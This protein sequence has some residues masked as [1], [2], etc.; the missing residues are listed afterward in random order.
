M[1]HA[2]NGDRLA[3]PGHIVKLNDSELEEVAVMAGLQGS[4]KEKVR[5]LMDLF[6]LE[7]VAVTAGAEGSR[8]YTREGE[9]ET[10]PPSGVDIVDTVGAGDAYAAVLVTGYLR[11]WAPQITADRAS[12][13]AGMICGIEGAL[14]GSREPYDAFREGWG[15]GLGEG[16]GIYIQMFSIHG[17][18][19]HENMELGRDADTGGQIKYVVELGRELA[20]QP[21]IGRVDLFTRLI[22]DRGIS[23]DYSQPVTE[24]SDGFRII[25]IQ[26]GGRKYMRKELLWDHLDEYADRTMKFIKREGLLPDIVHG[27]YADAGIVAMKLSGIFD[28]PFV[29][30]GHS[31]GKTKKQKLLDEGVREEEIIKRFRIDRRIQAE[32]DVLRNADLVVT[33]TRQEMEEQYAVYR[34]REAP[35]YRV[36]PPGVEVDRFYPFYHDTVNGRQK[37][38]M[39]LYARASVIAELDRFF[40]NR[41]KPL[42]L[43]LSRPDKRKNIATLITAYGEDLE[44]QAMANL[45]VFAGIRKDISD[46]ED[47]ERGVLTEML[48]LMD[49][50]DLYGKLAIPKK[51]DFE[52]EV[53]ELYRIAAERRGV[54]VN[55]ALTEPFGLTLLEASGCGLPIISTNDGGPR[56]IVANCENGILVDPTD[57]RQISAA[58]RKIITDAELWKTVLAQRDRQCREFY[59]WEAHCASYVE[60]I[61]GIISE[62]SE[63]AFAVPM[64]DLPVGR[65]LAKLDFFLV[66]DIDNTLTGGERAPLD[67]L[68]CLLGEHRGRVGFAVATGRTVDSAVGHLRDERVPAPDIIISSVGSE[69]Y[70]GPDLIPDQGWAAHISERW[71]RARMKDVL[72]K[73]DFL[74]YQEEDTQ[75]QFKL[76]YYMEPRKDRIQKIHTLLTGAKCSYNLIYSHGQFLDILPR[77]S[78][79]GK[80]I[81]YL[82]YKWE[83]PLENIMVCGDSGNDEEML[84]ANRWA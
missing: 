5:A 12:R 70:Y 53:P 19:R 66:T 30:T 54:F 35:R 45:A 50:Y 16:S 34:N 29:F 20:R 68:I 42:I 7:I 80:A 27:H 37:S 82:S 59:T 83:V 52:Y 60:E 78:S 2:G 44:L 23:E 64:P 43:A 25:R 26:C 55:P 81:R 62:E 39:E 47:N 40:L 69:I 58:I 4:G 49:K 46:K 32:E 74:E 31:L 15:G 79:K 65:R 18:L 72:S 6:N 75:R 67:E 24:V 14:P 1:L 51:H 71:D 56:D 84:R 9:Y 63:R 8:L 48:L 76:S 61:T 38:E 57:S 21:G 77:R 22:S 3:E 28:V 11:G 33:S 10:A 73:L 36:I 13:F 41:D 17:L